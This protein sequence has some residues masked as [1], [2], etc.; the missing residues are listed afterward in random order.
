MKNLVVLC[1]LSFVLFACNTSGSGGADTGSLQALALP[2]PGH[3]APAELK[4]HQ[5]R[6]SGFFDS[7][8][9][10][11]GFNGSILVAKD[12][13][14]LYENYHGFGDLRGKDPIADTTAFH[15]ASTSKT[16]TG[17]AILQLVQQNKLSLD[18]SIQRF[19]PSLPY[20]GISV[21]MLLNHRSGLPNYV[22]FIPNSKWDKKVMVMNEDVLNTLYTDKPPRSFSPDIRFSYSNTNYVLLAMIAEKIT[23]IPFPQYMQ[24]RIFGPLGMSHTY[25]YTLA[26]SA[27]ALPSFNYNNS[28]WE[29]DFLEGTYGDKNIYSTPRDL[30]KW[31]QALYS[32][33]LVNKAM[34]DSAFKPYSHERPS[35]HNY[36]LGF[37][38]LN[39]PTGKNVVYHF[40]RWHGFNAAFARLTDE[41]VTVIILGNKFNRNIYTAAQRVYPLFG[42]YTTGSSPEEE[43][44]A[45][46]PPRKKKR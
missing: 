19:F 46:A 4:A 45:P 39:F 16:F 44:D 38:L 6:L 8:L 7:M 22:Y 32:E 43:A 27:R 37:R 29:N 34:L 20:P 14:I 30:L 18:D 1:F 28:F 36:G 40:G 17:V 13:N 21:R 26:D 11:K 2:K 33:V 12:G 24:Q 25:V 9:L 5:E 35:I 3:I 42:D 41:R 23:G 10:T 15:I 31:D